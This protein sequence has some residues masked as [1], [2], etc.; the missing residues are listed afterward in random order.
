MCGLFGFYNYSGKAI[1]NLCM[2]TNCLAEEAT[3]RGTDAAGIAYNDKNRLVIHKE[4]KSAYNIS[5]KHPYNTVCV[6]GHT[7]HATQGD[8]KQNQNNHPFGGS[9]KNLRFALCHNGVLTNDDTLR[10]KYHF[11]RTKIKTDSYAAVQL[12]E[13]YK[14]LNGD[15][16]KLMAEEVRGSF[17][18]TI[19]DSADT[20]WLVRGD[21]PLSLIHL[22]RYQIYVYAST[23][24]ILFKALVDTDL[25]KEIKTGNFEEISVREG[26]ILKITPDGEIETTEF[27]YEEYSGGRHWWEYGYGYSGYGYATASGKQSCDSYIEDLKAVAVYQGFDEDEI[28]NLLQSGFSPEEI[29]DLIYCFE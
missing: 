29:E 17:A 23:D 24:E 13:K 6:T 2:L 22:P 21:S 19:L 18:F 4:P 7:R 28:D 9:C 27:D 25:F 20:L 16:I 1:K 26:D 8:K 10:K 11:P 12:L 15:N 14:Q 3:I 5:F